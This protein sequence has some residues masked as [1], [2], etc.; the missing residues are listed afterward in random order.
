MSD[1]D[2]ERTLSQHT[3]KYMP[4]TSDLIPLKWTDDNDA[5]LEGLLFEVGRFYK[6]N[7]LF[8]PFFKH[9]AAV[10]SNGKLAVDSVQAVFFTSNHQHRDPQP[11]MAL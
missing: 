1:H 4:I 2:D 5:H 6:R 11:P 8:Q 3:D 9:H 7:A 10:L